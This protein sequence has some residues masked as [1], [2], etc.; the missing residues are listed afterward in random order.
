MDKL[1]FFSLL[2]FIINEFHHL[3]KAMGGVVPHHG[4]QYNE[5]T[6]TMWWINNNTN[7]IGGKWGWWVLAIGRT[8]IS[9]SN[10]NELIKAPT[11]QWIN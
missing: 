9:T 6:T 11:M 5:P 2:Y 10:D 1:K 8:N 7:N 4:M 3:H